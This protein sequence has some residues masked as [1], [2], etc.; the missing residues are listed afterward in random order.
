[1]SK[2][3]FILGVSGSWKWTIISELLKT[4][5]F[6]YS[7]SY[8]TREMR[9]WEINWEKYRFISDEDF[10][11]AI[12]NDEFLEYN[13]YSGHLYGTKKDIV[14][15]LQ[16]NKI[17]I[18]ELDSNWLSKIIQNHQIDK[19][20]LSI[21]FDISEDVMIKRITS[22]APITPEDLE[23]RLARANEERTKAK[24]ICNYIVDTWWDSSNLENNILKIKTIL[25]KELSNL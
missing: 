2:I 19:Q 15:H 9:P 25:D 6:I 1:M 13:E 14:A 5:K 11:K 23:R 16:W 22:R 12:D 8:S 3:I 21:F 18:K 20:F 10:R 7:P 24:E 17:P 4:G